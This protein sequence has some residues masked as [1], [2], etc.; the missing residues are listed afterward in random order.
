MSACILIPLALAAMAAAASERP[1]VVVILADDLGWKDLGSYGSTFY[2]TPSL[3]EM[4]ADGMRF[5][6]A[7]AACP[8]CSPTRSS[9]LTGRYPTRTGVTDFIGAA[10]PGKWRRKTP[11]LPAPYDSRLATRELTLAE[12]LR[13]DGYRTFFAGKWHLGPEGSWPED[14]GFEVNRGGWSAGGPYGGKKYFSPYGNPRL[15]DGPEGEHLPAR[16]AAETVRFIEDHRDEPFFAYLSFYSVH[17]PLIARDDLRVKY[18]RRAASL[19]PADGPRFIPEGKREARQVQDHAVYAGMVE[20]MDGAVGDVLAAIDRLGLAENTLVVFTSDNGGL[21]TSEGS[22]TSNVPLRAGKGWM[23]E[24]GIRE[25]FI[26]RWPGVVEAG[27]T[28]AT[29][30]SSPDLFPTILEVTRSRARPDLPLDGKSLVPLLEGR[31]SSRDPLFWHYPHYG[32]QGGSPSGAVRDG[33]WKLIEWFED[34]RV[35]LFHLRSD[36]GETRDLSTNESTRAERM[37]YALQ[38]WRARTGARF[39]APAETVEEGPFVAR[40]VN[41]VRGYLARSEAWSDAAL[42]LV[43]A[44][45]DDVVALVRVD[46]RVSLLRLTHGLSGSPRHA[47]HVGR[48]GR[49]TATPIADLPL[50]RFVAASYDESEETTRRALGAY[51]RALS[52]GDVSA[53][54]DMRT[55]DARIGGCLSG[56]ATWLGDAV[57]GRWARLG[58]ATELVVS[59][60]W[61]L[62]VGPYVAA[63]H[64]VEGAVDGRR[65]HLVEVVLLRCDDDGRIADEWAFLESV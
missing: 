14:H 25:P 15:D 31:R 52:A 11:L 18:E 8:V 40:H 53:L 27:S 56:R 23:Y 41:L 20:A 37:L 17:T 64:E 43:L 4:A 58:A 28:C 60:A 21:S 48:E 5:T 54:H 61:T 49:S 24:G 36:P 38:D 26:V 1:N 65:F 6:D 57:A 50:G 32:N 29:P 62:P 7:Y 2:E 55:P 22:P 3:D 42:P 63:A 59:P 39:P 51:R 10:Q 35:E 16:L 46:D 34:G 47:A 45:G 33:P 9:L 44:R 12:A 19:P 30:V 13:D